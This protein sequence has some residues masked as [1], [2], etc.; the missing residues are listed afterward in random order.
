M[1]FGKI[2][3]LSFNKTF[4]DLLFLEQIRARAKAI[5]DKHKKV[6][7]KKEPQLPKTIKVHVSNL[8]K[9]PQ[10]TTSTN[11][12][13]IDQ[14][15]GVLRKTNAK[16]GETLLTERLKQKAE[17]REERRHK[18]VNVIKNI[19]HAG[20]NERKQ[21]VKKKIRQMRRVRIFP[22]PKSYMNYRNRTGLLKKNSINIKHVN[23]NE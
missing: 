6:N 11:E 18:N 3:I 7:P 13:D 10:G 9:I 14:Y 8:P 23:S 20:K 19:L 5:V 17:E 21:S 16:I 4:F 2:L 22:L 1:N 15:M 12:K